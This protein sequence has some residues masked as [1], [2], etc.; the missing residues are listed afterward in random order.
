M[1][2][3]YNGKHK[4]KKMSELQQHINFKNLS[5]NMSHKK[6]TTL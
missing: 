3:L 5:E 6:D 4:A 2:Y 1:L